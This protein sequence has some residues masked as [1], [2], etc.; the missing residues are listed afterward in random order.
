MNY[1]LSTGKIDEELLSNTDF[2][3]SEEGSLEIS[4]YD[5]DPQRA[6]DMANYFVRC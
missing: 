3:L 2:E 5:K 4:V 1:T 6:A